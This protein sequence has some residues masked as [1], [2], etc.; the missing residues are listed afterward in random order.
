[1]IL[2][3]ESDRSD[4]II[5]NQEAG[6]LVDRTKTYI[7]TR[8]QEVFDMLSQQNRSASIVYM[9]I[10]KGAYEVLAASGSAEDYIE[11]ESYPLRDLDFADLVRSY[12]RMMM[13][14]DSLKDVRLANAR[15]VMLGFKT[16]IGM[17]IYNHHKD[18]VGIFLFMEKTPQLVDNNYVKMVNWL[19]LSIE[20]SIRY[21]AAESEI[22]AIR[23]VDPLTRLVSREK[24]MSILKLEFE[25]SQRSDMPYSMVLIDIDDFKHVNEAFGH[26]VGD[27]VLKEF[28]ELILS[29]IRMVDTAC[30][31][32]GDAFAILCPQTDLTSANILVNDLFGNLTTHLFTTV[33][34]CYFS[35]GIA[36]FSPKDESIN[37][38]I[39]RLDKALYRVKA[40][41]GNSHETRYH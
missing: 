15:E 41:G 35:M 5:M 36:D 26:E 39:L 22:N 16:M 24:M 12:G 37:D 13:V 23:N 2:H 10:R 32:D 31:W 11:N 20:E 34:R 25:R 33:G 9:A 3:R 17:P 6:K 21:M 1:M 4:D 30:R 7:K 29:R 14:E 18:M 28:S 38:M 40:F 19:G 27:K 8:W